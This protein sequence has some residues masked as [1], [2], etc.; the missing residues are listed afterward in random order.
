[1]RSLAAFA[2]CLAVTAGCRYEAASLGGAY[3]TGTVSTS[4]KAGLLVGRPVTV[5]V[6][7]FQSD[8]AQTPLPNLNVRI[9][10]SAD[11]PTQP[12]PTSHSGYTAADVVPRVAGPFEV[13]AFI[14]QP[15][16]PDIELPA[17]QLTAVATTV[18]TVVL[19]EPSMLDAGVIVG[20]A[21]GDVDGDGAPDLIAAQSNLA[22]ALLVF[23]GSCNVLTDSPVQHGLEGAPSLVAVGRFAGG[24]RDAVAVARADPGSD[25]SVVQA[26]TFDTGS[27]TLVGK[28][29]Q[30]LQDVPKAL[31]GADLSG[32]G[33]AVAVVA[34][35]QHSIGSV[36][37]VT[38]ATAS[39]HT[40]SFP[41]PRPMA[42]A[43]GRVDADALDDVA[44]GL[45]GS[46][47]G[48][49]VVYGGSGGADSN[50]L[51]AVT[52]APT[53]LAI[54]DVTGD[55]KGDIIAVTPTRPDPIRPVPDLLTV[56]SQDATIGASGVPSFEATQTVALDGAPSALAVGD[57]N[58][59][60]LTDVVVLYQG[61]TAGSARMLVLVQTGG[62]LNKSPEARVVADRPLAAAVGDF[63]QDSQVD[64]VVASYGQPL[65][66][67]RGR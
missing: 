56:W 67:F 12:E 48:I 45:S 22:T 5:E 13:K 63:D 36:E 29:K 65:R 21:A 14:Q 66:L 64:V 41:L 33:T 57:L 28:G 53:A 34:E 42:L 8:E 50:T 55:G 25:K 18:E 20:L 38:F 58:G 27:A 37:L 26:F 3:A 24:T 4:R 52:V 40:T 6:S 17:L 10:S 7:L 11:V 59:D 31:V 1:M 23:R 30:E 47:P 15:G 46:Q 44:I 62:A 9:Q 19:S 16:L 60:D 54:G 2:L 39:P 61:A 51:F 49:V 43:A 32:S 35:P